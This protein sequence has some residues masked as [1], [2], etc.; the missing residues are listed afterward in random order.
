MMQCANW[1]PIKAWVDERALEA[2]KFKV[3]PGLYE[4]N[5]DVEDNHMYEGP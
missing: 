2:R 5:D 1:T 4:D 3:R